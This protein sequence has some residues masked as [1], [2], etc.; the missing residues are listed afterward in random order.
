MFHLL[1]GVLRKLYP[2]AIQVKDVQSSVVALL[3]PFGCQWTH[4]GCVNSTRK[5]G[6]EKTGN[7]SKCR[8]EESTML[9]EPPK[10]FSFFRSQ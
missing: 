10:R 4:K 6:R 5:A 3:P 9:V 7:G 8:R 2:V 1:A